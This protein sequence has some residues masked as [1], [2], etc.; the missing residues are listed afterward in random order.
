MRAA[1][2]GLHAGGRSDAFPLL[3][4]EAVT[5]EEL[6]RA[7]MEG[8][9]VTAPSRE[10]MGNGRPEVSYALSAMNAAA[11]TRGDALS[12]SEEEARCAGGLSGFT[13]LRRASSHVS[14]LWGGR[15]RSALGGPFSPALKAQETLQAQQVRVRNQP[16]TGGLEVGLGEGD[17]WA[18]GGQLAEGVPAG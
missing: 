13:L 5:E 7:L 16:F 15:E 8:E 9:E 6:S 10:G 3:P 2:W 1:A 12:Y 14:L 18:P 11:E 17:Q 4:L